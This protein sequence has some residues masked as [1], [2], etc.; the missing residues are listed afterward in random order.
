MTTSSGSTPTPR[1]PGRILPAANWTTGRTRW[2]IRWCVLPVIAILAAGCS[3]GAR[4]ASVADWS[5][6]WAEAQR[7][8]PVESS[9]TLP[10]NQQTCE[11]V[12]VSLRK[13]REPLTA[14]PDEV[15]EEAAGKWLAQAEHM[16]FE[17]FASAGSDPP[18]LA[19]KRLARLAG[20][21]DEALATAPGQTGVASTAARVAGGKP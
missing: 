15:I 8:V 19:Y 11:Q 16:F 10:A 3:A 14:S 20:L 2:V 7:L 5:V 13:I 6:T 4:R 9:L 17:C 12:L 21:V 1:P 18:D